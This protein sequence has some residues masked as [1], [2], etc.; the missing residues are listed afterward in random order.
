MGKFQSTP[1]R[2][3]DLSS[4][5]SKWPMKDFNPR[6]LAGATPFAVLLPSFVR[7]SIHA[8]SRGRRYEPGCHLWP[9]YFNPRPLAGATTTIVFPWMMPWNFNP[10]PLAGATAHM[11]LWS[12]KVRHFNPR[13]LAGATIFLRLY[14]TRG[15][16]SIHAPSRGRPSVRRTVSQLR[17]YFNPR[18][19]AGATIAEMD[20]DDD[21]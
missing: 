8:P 20:P 11:V 13:P 5:S 4:V 14:L 10:R 6:P 19:L 17:T 9:Q 2:G 16:I 1:P 18:P 3:G 7:I 12:V 15:T 21:I